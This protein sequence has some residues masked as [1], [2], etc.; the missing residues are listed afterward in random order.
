M[1]SVRDESGRTMTEMLAVIGIIAVLSVGGMTLG[2]YVIGGIKANRVVS[3]LQERILLAQKRR[4]I[5]QSL[6]F[7]ERRI[8]ESIMGLYPVEYDRSATDDTIPIYYG[9]KITVSEIPQQ[10]CEGLKKDASLQATLDEVGG[11]S[12]LTTAGKTAPAK[13]KITNS[14]FCSA[15]GAKGNAMVGTTGVWHVMNIRAIG[16]WMKV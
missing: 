11:L 16:S 7:R 2:G 3:G 8:E 12:R 9:K 1:T 10:V 14:L 4:I 15:G 5:G 13:K 6:S